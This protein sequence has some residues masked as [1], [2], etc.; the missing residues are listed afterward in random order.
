MREIKFRS[1]DGTRMYYWGFLEEGK[2]D[3]PPSSH[4]GNPFTM[5]QM[6]F[7]GLLDK[8]GKEI[9]EG[10]ILKTNAPLYDEGVC[11]VKWSDV[12]VGWMIAMPGLVF[13]R[14]GAAKSLEVIGN[15]FENPELLE[16]GK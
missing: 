10:D 7:T 16:G 6:Q 11:E 3:G 14:A 1:W 2:F 12:E 15:R 13:L 5:E 8:N 4:K 9:Y